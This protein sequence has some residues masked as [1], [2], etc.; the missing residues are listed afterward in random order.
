MQKGKFKG[1]F[2]V[3]SLA[4]SILFTSVLF[5]QNKTDKLIINDA[6]YFEMP[7]LNVLVYNNTFPEGH[8]G[9]VE[10]IQHG[11]RI[12]TNGELRLNATPGQWQPIPKLEGYESRGVSPLEGELTSRKV[13]K[14]NNSISMPLSYPDESRMRKGF[15]PIVYPDINIKYNVTVKAEGKSFTITV[16]LDEPLP[17]EY[18]DKV[19]YILELF[20]GDLFGKTYFMD[21]VNGVFPRQP[22]GPTQLNKDNVVEAAPMAT[23]K[24]LVV[25]PESDLLRMVIESSNADLQL[26]DGS[27][28]HNNG[29]FTLR[30]VVPVGASKGAIKWKISPNVIT[31]WIEKPIV[32][33]SQVG[34]HPNQPKTAFI[35]LDKNDKLLNKISLLKL[36]TDGNYKTI[37]EQA[38]EAWGQY[39]RYQYAKFNFTEIK[40][41]GVYV[42]KYGDF[43]TNVFRINEDVYKKNV[44]QPTLEYF[45]PVQMCHMRVNQ[46]YRV[47]HGLC[48][49]DDALMMPLNIRHFDGYNNEAE[50]S[51]LSKFKPLEPVPGLNVGGWHDAGDYDLRIESQAQTVIAL[52]LA[53]EEFGVEH[54]V[55]YVDQENK[56]VELLQPDGKADIL[57]Q[58]EHGV[59]AILSGYRSMGMLYRGI[60]VPTLRQYVHLGDA[61]SH[62]DNKFCEE[63][64]LL[65][66]AAKI[67]EMWHIKVANRY[68]KIFDPLLAFKEI[69]LEV[70]TLDDRLVFMETNP[71][72]QL[73]GVNSLA[74]S[75][76]VLKDYNPELAKECL[77]A[78]EDLYNRFK[79]GKRNND[80]YWMRNQKLEAL[81]ELIITTGK[82]EYKEDLCA[83][84]SEVRKSFTHAGWSLGRVM[85]YVDCKD[86]E[87][88]VKAAAVAYKP[89]Y[90]KMLSQSPYGSPMSNTEYVAFSAYYLNKFWPE[91]YPAEHLYN[92]VNYLL[93]C[94]PGNTTNSLVSGVGVNS[95]TIAYGTN[96][97]DWSYIPGGTFWN[98][99]N[100]V[101]PDYAEDKEWPF[102]WQEREYIIT[103]PCYFMFSVLGADKILSGK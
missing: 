48:H 82:K 10:I 72:W 74:I 71:D 28:Q 51:T 23:G 24:K 25:A 66:K 103:A 38:P 33:I 47:W 46:K 70:P 84:S 101:S 67:E 36:E 99:V 97:A 64:D 60:I 41:S 21:N 16:D 26:I 83:M 96:R 37:K 76:R 2:S 45:V 58:V 73:I 27:L 32:H 53:Y 94:R 61:G 81:I 44:W 87:D 98:A 93:G 52:G 78:A 35:E 42:V 40:E 31:D 7:G 91:L 86:F 50:N 62:T 9:G 57:Q 63:K 85:S 65:E 54:D 20:P 92:V 12:A 75:A 59:L 5:A 15:N 77:V 1:V 34:Y 49:Q 88:S 11:N 14:N 6:G 90:E 43:T 56:H 39:L 89:V 68:S 29:W 55:T 18:A 80:N 100:L 95:P 79:D 13:D 102:I 17:A 22:H 3:I 4:I 69:E 30:S 19:G 8:Q